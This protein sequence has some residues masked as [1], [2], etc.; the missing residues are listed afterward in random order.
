MDDCAGIPPSEDFYCLNGIWV[1]NASN[2]VVANSTERTG[3]L[4]APNVTRAVR[5]VGQGLCKG[6]IVAVVS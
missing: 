3:S 5:T 4:A 2:P 1:L 6:R